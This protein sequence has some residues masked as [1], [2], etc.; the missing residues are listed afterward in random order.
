[1]SILNFSN[2]GRWVNLQLKDEEGET[3]AEV[4]GVWQIR[5]FPESAGYQLK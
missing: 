3:V 2:C 4:S 5:K 1:M